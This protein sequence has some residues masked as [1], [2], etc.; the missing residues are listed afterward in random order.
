MADEGVVIR[1]Y[2]KGSEDAAAFRQLNESWIAQHFSLEEKDRRTLGDP[3]GTILAKGGRILM[4]EES[5]TA[6]GCVALIP[7][8]DGVVE[9]SK[10]T[11]VPQMRGRGLGRRLLLQGIAEARAMGMS[12]IFLGSNS[13]LADAV[14]LYESTGF[15]HVPMDH[16]PE[17]PYTRANVFMEMKL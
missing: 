2:V 14:H 10:M 5:G 8:G 15:Q 13:K 4:V 3:D 7:M 11:V 1:A 9:L 12:R 16:L 6:M 17:M